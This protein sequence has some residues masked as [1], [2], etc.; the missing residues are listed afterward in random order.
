MAFGDCSKGDK[1]L[2]RQAIQGYFQNLFD[3]KIV[4][5]DNFSLTG[6]QENVLVDNYGGNDTN[7]KY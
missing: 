4:P 7:A 2:S 5:E 3:T 6:T 1:E